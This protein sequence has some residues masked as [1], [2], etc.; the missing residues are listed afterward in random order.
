[1]TGAGRL[2]AA[3]V[4]T[5]FGVLTHVRAMQR[6]GFAVQVL[7]GRDRDKAE[8]RA[9]LF[10]VPRVAT[11]LGEALQVPGVDAVAVVTPPVAHGPLVMETLDA[12]RHV[13]CEKPFAMDAAEARSMLE[14]AERAGVVHLVGTEFRF[15][16]AQAQLTRAV[17]GGAIGRPRHALFVLQLPTLA[18]PAAQIPAWWEDAAAGG[19][20]LGAQG[21][22]HI[23]Q[24]LA[25]LGGI[26]AVFA[27]LRTL[28]PRPAM[29][30]DDTYTVQFR[31]GG[32]DVE[33]VLVGSCAT[34]GPFFSVTRISGSEATVWIDGADPWIDD[35]S[36][37]RPLPVDADLRGAGPPVPP[38]AELL[39]TAYDR[40]HSTGI[41]LDPFTR[42]YRVMA[43]RI[44]GEAVADD[45]VPA[46]FADG[47]AAQ[48]VM[49]AVR[50]SSAAGTWVPVEGSA[51][52]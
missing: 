45:P 9:G 3:V 52:S 29:T 8:H 30:A 19:G 1:M 13:L 4:G 23:D 17:A 22:H 7:V 50:R 51:A 38:P 31:A 35:G 18:D 5:G 41:D 40:W 34:P 37:P 48:Q 6:A 20:W 46:T 47:L 33:G 10:G 36:G 26:E 12:G 39:R 14:A 15:A 2:G 24:V 27:T 44:A 11:S 43:A 25:T 49:D 21:S 32:A 28:A 42:L 16:P